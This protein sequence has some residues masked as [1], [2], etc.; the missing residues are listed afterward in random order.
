MAGS[1]CGSVAPRMAADAGLQF[2]TETSPLH[3]ASVTDSPI[4]ASAVRP[5]TEL[6]DERK[7]SANGWGER[8]ICMIPSQRGRKECTGGPMKSCAD[9]TTT[10][11]Q[12][13]G[14]AGSYAE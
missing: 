13:H 7:Q 11:K 2:Y 3:V 5:A 9:S 1:E 4:A 12:I 8:Q 14:Q 6:S 10:P